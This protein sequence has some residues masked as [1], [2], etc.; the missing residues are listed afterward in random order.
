MVVLY[1]ILVILVAEL[2]MQLKLRD[3]ECATDS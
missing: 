1:I 3:N 2:L